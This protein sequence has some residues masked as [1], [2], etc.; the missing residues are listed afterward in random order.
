[1]FSMIIPHSTCRLKIINLPH[2][3]G[4]LVESRSQ[5]KLSKVQVFVCTRV[6]KI[7]ELGYLK[8]RQRA[9]NARSWL[10]YKD[11]V[12]WW[13]AAIWIDP[14]SKVSTSMAT[15]TVR[16]IVIPK[17]AKTGRNTRRAGLTSAPTVAHVWITCKARVPSLV[18]SSSFNL[19]PAGTPIN[20]MQPVLMMS[21]VNIRTILCTNWAIED[22]YKR[23]RTPAMAP[24]TTSTAIAVQVECLF[25]AHRW[26][27]AMLACSDLHSRWKVS[28]RT[29]HILH[30]IQWFNTQSNEKREWA[31]R[32][33]PP[34][35]NSLFC[36]SILFYRCQIGNWGCLED[37][38][39]WFAK[40]NFIR[41][42]KQTNRKIEVRISRKN[43]STPNVSLQ[44]NENKTFKKPKNKNRC[45]FLSQV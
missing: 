35:I 30:K 39:Q 36:T 19:N 43:L 21:F 5:K 6:Q 42:N 40:K 34:R 41:I 32:V 38:N 31:V 37:S 18:A 20:H 11:A 45:S 25:C 9:A 12:A 23:T 13:R 10:A 27:M 29:G 4:G 2:I 3:T 1:M 7:Y 16:P 28:W 22:S 24:I 33:L 14:N 26:A 17:T 8:S 44:I 15:G